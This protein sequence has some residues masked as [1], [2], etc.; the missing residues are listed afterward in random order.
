M[1]NTPNNSEIN[2]VLSR[3]FA[4]WS[5]TMKFQISFSIFY[6]AILLVLA[7]FAFNYFGIN[8]K[9]E[10]FAPLIQS[11]PDAFMAK[12]RE[13]AVTPEYSNFVYVIVLIKALVFPL[14]IGMYKVYALKEM[15]E[16]PGLNDMLA[17]YQG[18]SFFKYFTYGIFWGCVYYL[19]SIFAPLLLVWVLVTFFVSPLMFFTNINSFQAIGKSIQAIRANFFTIFVCTIVAI[20]FSYCGILMFGFGILLTF[21]FWN[22][23]I[24]SCFRQIFTIRN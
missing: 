10:D 22:A 6:F 17:G 4:L 7:S 18:I 23:I 16:N 8:K 5:N 15:G 11:D 19:C 14:N 13:L 24:Y 12:L 2:I 9:V 21:P 1:E 3:A 20:L